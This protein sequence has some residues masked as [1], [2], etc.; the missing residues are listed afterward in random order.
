[1]PP[2]TP[3]LHAVTV[4]RGDSLWKLAQQNLGNGSRWPELLAV[5]PRIAN[6][7]QIK[8][9][10]QLYLPA[11]YATRVGVLKISVRKGDTLWHL[12]QTHFGRAASWPCIAGANP[13]IQDANRIY[14][15]Q[16]LILPASCSP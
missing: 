2:S 13:A 5:N 11:R 7:G 15:G 4:Q 9:G 16:E 1:L 3:A 14:E 10:A 8:A 6:P 12:A